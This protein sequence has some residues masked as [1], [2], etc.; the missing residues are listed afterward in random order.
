MKWILPVLARV[1]TFGN[2]QAQS[3]GNMPEDEMRRKL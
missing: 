1:V 3:A 2:Q